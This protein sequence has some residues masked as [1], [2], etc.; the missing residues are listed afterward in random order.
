MQRPEILLAAPGTKVP[1]PSWV[2]QYAPHTATGSQ[3]RTLRRLPGLTVIQA[4]SPDFVVKHRSFVSDLAIRHEKT[5]S[6]SKI[7]IVFDAKR[8]PAQAPELLARFRASRAGAWR[9]RPRGG[10]APAA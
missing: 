7:L 1:V 2:R 8:T 6:P 9:P 4:E 10:E 5:L 3:V